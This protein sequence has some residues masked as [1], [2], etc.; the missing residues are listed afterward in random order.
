MDTDKIADF[1]KMNFLLVLA[2][3]PLFRLLGAILVLLVT[4][5]K[6]IYGLFAGLVWIVW[7]YVGSVGA[8]GFFIGRK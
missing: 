1:S 4:D 5:L 2:R 3:Q 6:P 8:N 7:V